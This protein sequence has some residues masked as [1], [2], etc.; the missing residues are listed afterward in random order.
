MTIQATAT[1]YRF[2][3]RYRRNLTGPVFRLTVTATDPDDARRMAAIRD[4]LYLSS[5]AVK[6]RGEVLPPESSDGLTSAKARD[7]LLD[8]VAHFGWHGHDIEVEV[9]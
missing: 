5:V 9:L 3:V 2:S 8:G 4:P 1:L 6:R 7:D